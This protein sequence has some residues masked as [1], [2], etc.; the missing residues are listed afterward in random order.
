MEERLIGNLLD[1]GMPEGMNALI[2]AGQFVEQFGAVQLQ[3]NIGK[4]G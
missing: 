4:L 3:D 2:D 1:Q